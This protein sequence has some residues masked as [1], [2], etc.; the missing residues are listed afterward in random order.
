MHTGWNLLVVLVRLDSS[1]QGYFYQPHLAFAAGPTIQPPPLGN[2]SSEL[3]IVFVTRCKFVP[4]DFVTMVGWGNAERC[5][6][7]VSTV[8]SCGWTFFDIG[9][10][11]C[12]GASERW[13]SNCLRKVLL[14]W[15]DARTRFG[16]TKRE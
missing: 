10:C 14:Y 5:V 15:Y 16:R 3:L 9:R 7:I 1:Q 12:S 4:V 13:A 6:N 2:D 11:R 8:C